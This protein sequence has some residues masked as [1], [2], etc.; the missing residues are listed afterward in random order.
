M[1]VSN[2]FSTLDSNNLEGNISIDVTVC[3]RRCSKRAAVITTGFHVLDISFLE[4]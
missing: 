1:A 3:S 2:E 4:S